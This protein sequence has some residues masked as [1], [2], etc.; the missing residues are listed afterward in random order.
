MAMIRLI[1][2]LLLACGAAAEQR[3]P[4]KDPKADATIESALINDVRKNP[5]DFQANHRLAEFYRAHERMDA[6]IPFFE[7]AYQLN[8]GDYSNAWDLALSYL[9][10][11]KIREARKLVLGLQSQ[12]D[13]AELRNLLGSIE[14]AAGDL[15]AAVLEYQRAARMEPSEKN[16]FD[17]ATGF[18][19]GKSYAEAR[20]IFIYGVEKYPNS[21]RMR[22][23]LAVAYHG[24]G[25]YFEAVAALCQAVDLDPDDSRPVY[26]LSSMHDISP[27]LSEHV[28]SRLAHLVEVHPNNPQVNYA[29]AV[30]LWKRTQT[31]ADDATLLKVQKHLLRAV[32]LDSKLTDAHF[33]LGLLYEQR[34]ELY[35][36]IREFEEAVRLEPNAPLHHY[37]LGR[38]YGAAGMPEKSEE[39]LRIFR[40]LKKAPAGSK[41]Q[42]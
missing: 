19:K 11:H 33:Q 7:K 28:T 4:A 16:I 37:R 6:A 15:R 36:A 29:Y 38:A 42:K 34:G 31:A 8:A 12:N 5:D 2:P 23:G 9:T 27:E 39:Q 14:E 17:Y 3:R 40:R 10:A 25:R 18:S 26:F 21:A 35:N 1:L 32:Q 30:S 20:Q 41:P 13:K 22:V 24:L